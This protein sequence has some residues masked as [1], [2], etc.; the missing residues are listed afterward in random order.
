MI[1]KCDNCLFSIKN[2]DDTYLCNLKE[3]QC[4]EDKAMSCEEFIPEFIDDYEED[5]RNL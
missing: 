2:D 3:E 4:D 1:S 5:G